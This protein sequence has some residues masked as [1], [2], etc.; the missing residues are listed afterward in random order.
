MYYYT[1]PHTVTL[2][3]AIREK[4]NCT[5]PVFYQKWGKQHEDQQ[6]CNNGNYFC[7]YEGIQDRLTESYNTFAYV[8]Q[9]AK[10]APAGEAWRTWSNRDILCISYS[11][12]VFSQVCVAW[13]SR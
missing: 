8:N 5:L 6:N 4:N 11:L 3:N 13:F 7:T 1:L 12:K 2:V 9:P 10:V